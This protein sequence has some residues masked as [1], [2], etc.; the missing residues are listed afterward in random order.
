MAATKSLV[1]YYAPNSR[2]LTAHWMLEELGQPYEMHVLNLQKNEQKAP[3]YLAVNPMGKVPAIA[4]DGVVVTEA[5]AICTYL[6]DAFPQA[7]L[8]IPVGDKRRGT[9]LRWLFFGPSCI[10][11][12]VVDRLFNRPDVRASSI[13]YGDFDTTL[14]TIARVL[15]PDSYLLGDQFTAA[16]IVIGG[17]LFWAMSTKAV[18]PRPEFKAYTQPVT[19]RPAWQ[20]IS[21]HNAEMAKKQGEG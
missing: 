21:Q 10:E 12:A 5:A 15:R 9:Y 6:A 17:G 3:D 13:G 7:G 1:F 4:H 18:P 11:P 16:D 8:A 20:R 2:A 19:A 14:D